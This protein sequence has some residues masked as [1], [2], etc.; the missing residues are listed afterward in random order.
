MFTKESGVAYQELVESVRNELRNGVV[1]VRFI[2]ESTGT[3]REMVC[4][5]D[6][7]FLPPKK[8]I[9]EGEVEK[10]KRAQNPDVCVVYDIQ[11]DG[12]RSFRYDSIVRY[13]TIDGVFEAKVGHDSKPK[14]TFI[15]NES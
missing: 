3:T 15:P 11:Q 5:L 10:P 1:T 13:S 6:A 9:V 2:K 14:L 7:K 8:E 4:T 12:W